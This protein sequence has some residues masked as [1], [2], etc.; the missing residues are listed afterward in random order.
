MKIAV[1]GTG[2]GTADIFKFASG[3]T[4]ASASGPSNA[5]TFT[6]SYIAN[7]AGSTPAGTYNTSLN[8]VATANFQNGYNEKI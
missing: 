2:Y 7:I 5:N 3:E 8:Y 4:V 1:A 6:V